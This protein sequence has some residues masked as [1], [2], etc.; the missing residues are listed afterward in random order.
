MQTDATV[1]KL[2]N[3]LNAAEDFHLPNLKSLKLR[4]TSVTDHSINTLISMCP[5]LRRL[6][7]SFT[8]VRKPPL[9]LSNTTLEKLSL[10]STQ[11]SAADLVKILTEMKGLTTLAVG[12]LGRSQDPVAAISN[13]TAMTMTDDTL[14]K[15]TN[16]LLECQRLERVSLV[17]NSKLGMVSRGALVDFVRLV[18]RRCKVRPTYDLNETPLKLYL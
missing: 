9:L 10:T 14:R 16:L 2:L 6:D 7:L 1:N 17:G 5:N 12:A 3:E 11:V 8:A 15:L 4:Q 18:G 13:T